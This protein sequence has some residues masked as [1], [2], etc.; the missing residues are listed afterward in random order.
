MSIF[1]II[2]LIVLGVIFLTVEFIIIPGITVAG[3]A[4]LILMVVANYFAF[5]EHGTQTGG[6]VLLATLIINVIVGILIFRKR[7]W[8]NIGL[9]SIVSGR[10]N[11]SFIN[12]KVGDKG[13]AVSRLAPL[14]NAMINNKMYEVSS[15]GSFLDE[16][17]EIEVIFIKHNK[18]IVKQIV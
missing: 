16:N 17:T 5:A 8:K 2:G 12:V 4:G 10:A 9:K 18:I 13:I 14:G 6:L 15:Q 1:V 7:T 3:I 11:E